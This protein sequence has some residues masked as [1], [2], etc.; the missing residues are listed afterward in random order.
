[1]LRAHLINRLVGTTAEE[2]GEKK[3]I[4][5]GPHLL[6]CKI[7]AT[8]TQDTHDLFESYQ[9]T[10]DNDIFVSSFRGRLLEGKRISIPPG[11]KGIVFSEAESRDED[12]DFQRKE[13]DLHYAGEFSEFTYW[14]Y[15]KTPSQDDPIIGVLD[16]LD[17]AESLHS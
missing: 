1:M 8:D 15:D 10:R 14:N 6:P 2:G 7:H 16:W 4:Q 5:R 11:Y 17:I 3:E 12:G 13:R 9:R